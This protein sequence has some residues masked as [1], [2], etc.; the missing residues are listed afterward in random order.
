MV[1]GLEEENVSKRKSL[2]SGTITNEEQARIAKWLRRQPGDGGLMTACRTGSCSPFG[3]HEFESHSGRHI[4]LISGIF[5]TYK[6]HLTDKV[7]GHH[8]SYLDRIACMS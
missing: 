7:G 1:F 4:F 5:L 3:R 6:G 8:L 2:K